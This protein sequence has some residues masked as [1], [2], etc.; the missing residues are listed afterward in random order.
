MKTTWFMLT[1]IG[2]DKP[3]MVAA[4]SGALAEHGVTLGET[5]MLRLGGNFT[6]MMMVSGSADEQALR[7]SLAPILESQGM[8]L[9]I[10]PIEGGL[11]KHVIPNVHVTVSGADR[12]GIV[13]Q[14]TAVLAEMGINILDLESDV[15][16]TEDKPIYIMQIS[17]VTTLD[18]EAIE[19]ALSSVR[20]T[21][22]SV[23]VSAIETYIG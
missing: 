4:I 7:E 5:S 16:G 9:H 22:V 14:V 20:E 6:V 15:A 23:N 17:A 2:K 19:A 10:D 13:S 12:P 8:C 18:I 11:H 21:D 3:G 1:M